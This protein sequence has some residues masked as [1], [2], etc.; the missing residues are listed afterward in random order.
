MPDRNLGRSDGQEERRAALEAADPHRPVIGTYKVAEALD[1]LRRATPA[2]VFQLAAD[3]WRKGKKR[4]RTVGPE[5]T[6][7]YP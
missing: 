6:P 1:Y 4:P 3:R 7:V 5:T 2:A